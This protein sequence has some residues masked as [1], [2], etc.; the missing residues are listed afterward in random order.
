[1]LLEEIPWQKAYPSRHPFRCRCFGQS[2]G[3]GLCKTCLNSL[4]ARNKDKHFTRSQL[5]KLSDNI[6]RLVRFEGKTPGGSLIGFHLILC[7]NVF[8]YFTPETQMFLTKKFSESLIPG[9]IFIVGSA[10]N[11]MEPEVANLKRVSYCIYQRE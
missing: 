5:W 6:K 11:L 1:M 10:E 3:N 2:K 4:P 9:G 7:R 8:I